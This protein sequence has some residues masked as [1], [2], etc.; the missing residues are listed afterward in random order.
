MKRNFHRQAGKMA[1]QN[2]QYFNITDNKT[3]KV[4]LTETFML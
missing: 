1:Q 3:I 4:S 2:N